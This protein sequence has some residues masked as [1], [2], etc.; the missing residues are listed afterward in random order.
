MQSACC[1]F[2]PEGLCCLL[3]VL[4]LSW[5]DC[6]AG[7]QP[8]ALFGIRMRACLPALLGLLQGKLAGLSA[9]NVQV[10]DSTPIVQG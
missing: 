1:S 6:L 5:N 7:L 10:K 9:S 8:G 3:F 2:E 4:A